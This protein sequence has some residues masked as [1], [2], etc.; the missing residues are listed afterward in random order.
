MPR[1]PPSSWPGAT[2]ADRLRWFLERCTPEPGTEHIR[3]WGE[4]ILARATPEAADRLF[5]M[6]A[7]APIDWARRLPQVRIP[8]LIVHGELDAFYAIEHMRYTQSLIP[9]S[10]LVVMD[11]SGHLPAMTRPLEVAGHIERFFAARGI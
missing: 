6:E 10:E 1:K 5:V 9:D 8:T 4:Y 3:R 11:G 7:E 2:H